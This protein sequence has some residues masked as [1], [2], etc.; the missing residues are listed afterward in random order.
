MGPLHGRGASGLR[1]SIN[2]QHI[3]RAYGRVGSRHLQQ[4]ER[5]RTHYNPGRHEAGRPAR[6]VAGMMK[7][8]EQVTP[9][10]TWETIRRALA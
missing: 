8:M 2:R 3:S 10:A 4:L 5:Q 1:P 9:T 6:G 7:M